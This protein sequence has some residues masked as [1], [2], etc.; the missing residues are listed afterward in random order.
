MRIRW[1]LPLALLVCCACAVP[2]AAAPKPATFQVGA[3]TESIAPNV[4]VYA[5][6]FGASPPIDTMNDPIEVRAFYVSNGKKAVAIAVVDAQAYFAAYQ[7]GPD[8]GITSAREQ[9]AQQIGAG[10][11]R[12]DIIVQA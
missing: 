2:V 1:S 6:G 4:P 10:M 8:Y 11:D 7:E 9:A 3:A 12:T 5:G